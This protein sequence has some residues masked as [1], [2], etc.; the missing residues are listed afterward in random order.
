VAATVAEA[1]IPRHRAWRQW[2]RAGLHVTKARTVL[3]LARDLAAARTSS[4]ELIDQALAAIVDPAGEGTR[5]FLHVDANGARAAADA[6]DALRK[7]GYVLSPLAG[8]PVSIKDLLDIAGQRTRAASKVLGERPPATADAA[9][10][11]RLRQA[12][13]VLIGRTN[14]TEFAFS[15]V[16]INPH[17]GTPGNPF[18]RARIPGGSSSGAA[19]SVADG[20]AVVAIGTDTGGRCGF[21]RRYAG[22]PGLSLRRGASRRMACCHS[23]PRSIP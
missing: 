5:T 21:R 20:M 6:Q 11:A 9:V 3:G 13:A 15:G 19:V 10:V 23:P 1:V 17:Y 22:S 7:A 2:R 4:R 8:L 16:G 14:M 12:G 18:D